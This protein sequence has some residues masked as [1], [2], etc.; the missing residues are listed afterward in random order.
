ML[1]QT[2]TPT[3]AA[4]LLVASGGIGYCLLGLL[5]FGRDPQ[6]GSTQEKDV[7]ALQAGDSFEGTCV[8]NI[9]SEHDPE[10][11]FDVLKPRTMAPCDC[12]NDSDVQFFGGTGYL[13]VVFLHS[14]L[15]KC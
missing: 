7:Q 9:A 2:P 13:L 8:W 6:I 10:S 15:Y 5:L 1:N 11:L 3:P 4:G 14:L 12:I